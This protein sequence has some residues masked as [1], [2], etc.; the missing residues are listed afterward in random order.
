MLQLNQLFVST[1]E[2][3]KRLEERNHDGAFEYLPMA[4]KMS[5]AS[6][7]PSK[8]FIFLTIKFIKNQND[9]E[10]SEN[11]LIEGNFIRILSGLNRV[12]SKKEEFDNVSI[13]FNNS[14]EENKD[15]NVLIAHAVLVPD[16]ERKFTDEELSI[17]LRELEE[18][19]DIDHFV[20]PEI[21]DDCR[22]TN[23][24]EAKEETSK[25]IPEQT[26]IKEKKEEK[27][28]PDKVKVLDLKDEPPTLPEE[29]PVIPEEKKKA[30][31]EFN[32]EDAWDYYLNE[33]PIN[34]ISPSS[35]ETKHTN[36]IE[37]KQ[38]E[39]NKHN[40]QDNQD[41]PRY[42]ERGLKNQKNSDV[43]SEYGKFKGMIKSLSVSNVKEQLNL[44]SALLQD[45]IDGKNTVPLLN[46]LDTYIPDFPLKALSENDPVYELHE[47]DWNVKTTSSKEKLNK[48]FCQSMEY[49]TGVMHSTYIRVQKGEI[50]PENFMKDVIS[51]VNKTLS[52]PEEDLDIFFARLRRALFSYYVLTPAINDPKVTDIKVI[53]HERIIV[54]VKGK[55]YTASDLHF[56]NEQDYILFIQSLLY[57]NKMIVNSPVLF[58]TDKDF[59]TDYILRFNLTLES[60]NSSGVPCLHIR[61]T[62]KK[63]VT[64]T[65]LIHKKMMDEKIASFLIN[66][67]RTCKG[68]CISGPSA[69][70]KTHLMNALIDYI[71]KEDSVFCIQEA[72]EL[73]TNVHPDAIFQHILRDTK[74]RLFMGLSELGQNGLLC[75]NKYF[76]IGEVKGS[77]ARDLLRASN[78]GHNCW[79][80]VHAQSAKETIPRLADYVKMGA[81]YSFSEA[82][83]MLKDLKT[84]VYVENF[85]VQEITK[86]AGYDEE[87]GELIY[88]PIYKRDV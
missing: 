12:F 48:A 72:E 42:Q 54:K 6:L 44:Q 75:D 56:I 30:K 52:I 70:G 82:V 1:L 36:I 73:F 63:K 9:E 79:C 74:G 34:N 20:P 25:S 37:N 59:N 46:K 27:D 77:E 23:I 28:T 66:E 76:I 19:F 29:K 40:K 22:D 31:S 85:K 39:H 84:I 61:K 45:T 10:A 57:R 4:K 87:K 50:E 18:Q 88:I 7:C 14:L 17:L 53:N 47:E 71:P 60:I 43:L 64:V 24:E 26:E 2:E 32:Y 5:Y 62:P 80:S 55:Q 51:Y 49:F 11:E 33:S 38:D 41:K 68:L 35:I 83:R 86:I 8:P 58:F 78:T 81:D 21:E 3:K 65:D 69:S 13:S 15:T 67:V 16:S